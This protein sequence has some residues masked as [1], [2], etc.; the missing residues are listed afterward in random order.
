MSPAISNLQSP[1]SN[2]FN[3]LPESV[4]RNRQSKIANPK[5]KILVHSMDK[6]IEEHT[7]C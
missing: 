1:T 2:P 7:A 3:P 5:S 4:N 6:Y